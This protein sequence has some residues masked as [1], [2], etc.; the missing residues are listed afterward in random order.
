MVA[1]SRAYPILDP[2]RTMAAAKFYGAG[3]GLYFIRRPR[4]ISRKPVR[5]G[6]SWFFGY[7]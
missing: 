7:R 2:L 4:A 1:L 5:W 6:I 3:R